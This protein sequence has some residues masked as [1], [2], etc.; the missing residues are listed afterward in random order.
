MKILWWD[1]ETTGL[2]P[3]KDDVLEVAWAVADLYRPFGFETI[4]TSELV[5]YRW[6]SWAWPVTVQDMHKKS[7]LLKALHADEADLKYLPEVENGIL[8]ALGMLHGG[9][10]ADPLP[11]EERPVLGG[12]SVGTFDLQFIRNVMPRL[13]ARLSHRVYDV[14]AVKLFC[15][16]LG[17]PK[18]P[19]GEAHRAAADVLE[20]VDH[21]R[22]CATWLTETLSVRPS[23]LLERAGL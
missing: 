17:M 15:R 16:S 7:G 21:A 12:A 1:C 22:R 19:K 13:G 8:H 2:D 14:S 6:C 23:L 11:T 18:L 9:E 5:N 4:L 10:L 3:R 20:A